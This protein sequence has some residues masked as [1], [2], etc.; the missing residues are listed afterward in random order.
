LKSN[1]LEKRKTIP[2]AALSSA[3][4]LPALFDLQG[5]GGTPALLVF[6][7]WLFPH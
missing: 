7:S 2:V 5:A 4:I 1:P 6:A 3:G